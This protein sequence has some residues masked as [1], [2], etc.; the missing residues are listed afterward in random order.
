MAG[1]EI[2]KASLPGDSSIEGFKLQTLTTDP[3]IDL[4]SGMMWTTLDG[5]I[6]FTAEDEN[7]IVSIYAIPRDLDI[8]NIASAVVQEALAGFTGG[9]GSGAS[10]ALTQVY[11]SPSAVTDHNFQNMLETDGVAVTVLYDDGSGAGNPVW[12]PIET[13]VKV[14]KGIGSNINIQTLTPT[15]VRVTVIANVDNLP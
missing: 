12:M 15:I 4:T 3:N 10:G 1:R 8:A 14:G 7:D 9:G 6:K 11:V 5:L 2:H 13:G